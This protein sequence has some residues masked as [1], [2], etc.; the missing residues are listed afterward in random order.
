MESEWWCNTVGCFGEGSAAYWWTRLYGCVRRLS[1]SVV[2]SCSWGL[3]F[4][5]DGNWHFDV[6]DMWLDSAV[7]LA[8]HIALGVP[9]SWGK[10]AAGLAQNWV[11]FDISVKTWH[12]G[13]SPNRLL[14]LCTHAKSIIFSD[15]GPR[16]SLESLVGKLGNVLQALEKLRP[17]VRVFYP[18]SFDH[19]RPFRHLYHPPDTGRLPLA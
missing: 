2:G 12:I 19:E 13:T 17:L 3:V 10:V 15:S 14:D 4:V 1:Y 6:R 16:R 18:L 11:G 7:I 9:I 5:G 8:L